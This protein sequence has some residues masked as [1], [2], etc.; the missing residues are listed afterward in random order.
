[1]LRNL[2][3]NM[4]VPYN[5]ALNKWYLPPQ[6]NGVIA[7]WGN[8]NILLP[9]GKQPAVWLFYFRTLS[10]LLRI[11]WNYSLLWKRFDLWSST[12]A[13][14]STDVDKRSTTTNQQADQEQGIIRIIPVSS[15]RGYSVAEFKQIAIVPQYAV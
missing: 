14:N 12:T 5:F 2:Y 7:A 1:M 3:I 15:N 6:T 11:L 13:K 8:H 9:Q 4:R 10:Q